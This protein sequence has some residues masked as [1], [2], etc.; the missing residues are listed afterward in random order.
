MRK[1]VLASASPRRKRLLEQLG[2][3]FEVDPSLEPETVEPGAPP[4]RLAVIMALAK[5]G[6]VV[7]RHPGAIVIAA[8]SFIVI[9]GRVM[10]KPH[11][12]EEARRMLGS[13]SGRAHTAVTGLVVVD[14][15]AGKTL[16]RSTETTVYMK[17]LTPGE[18]DNYVGT[19]EPLDKAGAY[20]I[21]GRAA[22]FIEKIEGDYTNVVGLPLAVLAGV[23][24][25][26]GVEI[27]G[28]TF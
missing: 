13:L 8:D 5:V 10:G 20:A 23:L 11:T 14:T 9:D 25:E 18:I 28:K 16:S 24:K 4:L 7:G 1:I 21:Q 12:P 6:A 26:F 27:T 17:K 2:L 19:G 15:A 3:E 22:A